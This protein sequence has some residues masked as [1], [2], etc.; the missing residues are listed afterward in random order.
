[1]MCENVMR[2]RFPI[3][4]LLAKDCAGREEDSAE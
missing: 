2:Q 1:M 3:A 4:R